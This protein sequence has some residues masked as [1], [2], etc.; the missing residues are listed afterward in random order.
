MRSDPTDL[1]EIDDPRGIVDMPVG[2][3][4]AAVLECVA[5]LVAGQPY[6]GHAL[7]PAAAQTTGERQFKFIIRKTRERVPT[8]GLGVG[9]AH[10]GKG[11][12]RWLSLLTS[13][14]NSATD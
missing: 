14:N 5:Y 11:W 6:S 8:R 12:R 4:Q 10:I 13:T 7:G 2:P 3:R 1:A 9:E